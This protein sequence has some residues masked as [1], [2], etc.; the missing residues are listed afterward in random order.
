METKSNFIHYTIAGVV[1]MAVIFAALLV[2]PFKDIKWGK[3]QLSTPETVTVSGSAKTQIKSQV[4]S[5]SAG[6]SSTKDSK[7]EAIDEVNKKMESITQVAVDFGIDKN[8]IKTE[9]LSVYQGEESYWEDGKQ[10]TRPS[11]WH[12]NNSL[13][14]KLR[15]TAK[16]SEFAAELFKTEAT[17]V[18]G[19]NFTVEN[20]DE[21][22]TSLMQEAI[23]DA[24]NK[25]EI[26]AIAGGKKLGGIVSIQE[27]GSSISPVSYSLKEAGGGGP[28]VEPGS[29]TVSKDIMVVFELK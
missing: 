12:V 9:N 7:Q 16:A 29:S 10:K 3:I 8:D 5:F 22:E 18:Y 23:K 28:A 20:Q 21:V 6:V 1:V 15:D 25:A 14:I 19:P 17:N 2:I 4:A 26:M 11:Q 13:S 27:S 24:R